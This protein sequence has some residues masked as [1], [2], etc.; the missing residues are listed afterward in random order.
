MLSFFQQTFDV[1]VLPGGVE[2]A[3]VLAEVLNT[4][5]IFCLYVSKQFREIEKLII[6][7][8]LFLHFFT[9]FYI[10]YLS[11]LVITFDVIISVY[12][13]EDTS[14]TAKQSWQ[15]YCC[16]MCRWVEIVTLLNKTFSLKV[17]F[18]LLHNL[19]FC[20][21]STCRNFKMRVKK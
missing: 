19:F 7:F 8:A 21:F 3:K 18:A 2:G 4:L 5:L 14:G 13:G 10:F 11:L 1:V 17:F 20:Q 15:F 16:D 12:R 6:D 9:F